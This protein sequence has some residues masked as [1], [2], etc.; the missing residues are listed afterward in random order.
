MA[1]WQYTF[2]VIPSID[3][4][5]LDA[6]I[7]NT[8]GN[9]INTDDE[10]WDAK[11][12]ALSELAGLEKILPLGKSWNTDLMVYGELEKNCIEIYLN[13]DNVSSMSFRI[14]FRSE[15]ENILSKLI[16]LLKE[17]SLTALSENLTVVPLTFEAM[18]ETIESSPQVSTWRKLSGDKRL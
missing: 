13:G 11:K 17:M 8:E 5:A 3:S 6:V 1:L 18:Q 15:Y 16:D 14:D 9:K 12:V 4:L 7:H 10:L 2:R